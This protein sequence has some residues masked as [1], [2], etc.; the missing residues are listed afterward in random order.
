MR[1]AASLQEQNVNVGVSLYVLAKHIRVPSFFCPFTCTF[2]KK[3]KKKK[4]K[5]NLLAWTHTE[6]RSL[7]LVHCPYD[8]RLGFHLWLS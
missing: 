6:N 7:Q 3:G 1:Q 5:K 8:S 4:K 2:Y